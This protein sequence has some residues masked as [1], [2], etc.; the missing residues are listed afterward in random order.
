[1]PIEIQFTAVT[2]YLCDPTQTPNVKSK[3]AALSHLYSLSSVPIA[4][5][6]NEVQQLVDK[7]LG[8]VQT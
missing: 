5:R 2:H 1:M 4:I 6:V 7:L 3:V 8:N